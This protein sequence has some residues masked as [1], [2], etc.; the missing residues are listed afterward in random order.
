MKGT[1]VNPLAPLPDEL[2]LEIC[3]VSCDRR[4]ISSLFELC[5]SRVEILI[6]ITVANVPVGWR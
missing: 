4:T 1:V 5:L 3:E 6:V 2:I